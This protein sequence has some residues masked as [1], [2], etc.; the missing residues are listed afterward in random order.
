MKSARKNFYHPF[1]DSFLGVFP[2]EI[3]SPGN[4]SGFVL[5]DIDL[6]HQP[7]LDPI[8]ATIFSIIW[9]IVL[10]LG[11]YLHFKI[12]SGLKQE[13]G[14][15]KDIT[16][17]FV[18]AQ[19][20]FWPL[21]SFFVATTNF[22]YPLNILIGE[23]FCS[24]SQFVISFLLSIISSHSLIAALMRYFFIV[25]SSK[26]ELHGKTNIKKLFLFLSVMIP[27]CIAIG[28]LSSGARLGNM[29]FINKCNGKHH[30]AF[31]TETSTI[32]VLKK[33]FCE[34][35]IDYKGEIGGQVIMVLKQ[36]SCMAST[37][38]WVIMGSNVTEGIIY[39]RL[40]SHMNR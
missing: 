30:E 24:L 4:I 2:E 34:I 6:Y 37:F 39:Y 20:I 36:L 16:G 28:K 5:E 33:S 25:H 23:W 13:T 22:V 29:S 9:M 21:L 8:V 3:S 10:V 14:I 7:V 11:L 17:I 32:N 18:P 26:V 35:A 38:S 15:L 27:L 31:L 19:M 1:Q 12:L 40:F